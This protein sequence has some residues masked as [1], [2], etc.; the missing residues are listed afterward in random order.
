MKLSEPKG[1]NVGNIF[2]SSSQSGSD[3]NKLHRKLLV[4]RSFFRAAD[5][6]WV[7]NVECLVDRKTKFTEQQ[8]TKKKGWNYIGWNQILGQK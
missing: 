8:L 2:L 3:Y 4:F 6:L 7:P 5:L 1:L